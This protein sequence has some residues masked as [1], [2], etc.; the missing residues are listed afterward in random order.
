MF[1]FKY[2]NGIGSNSTKQAD[3]QLFLKDGVALDYETYSAHAFTWMITV[4]E[5]L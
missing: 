1:D 4:S 5:I 3:V 2:V